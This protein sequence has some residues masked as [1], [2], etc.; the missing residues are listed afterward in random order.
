M[1]ENIKKLFKVKSMDIIAN[2]SLNLYSFAISTNHLR[3][4]TE[5]CLFLYDALNIKKH[6][7]SNVGDHIDNSCIQKVRIQLRKF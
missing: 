1:C 6:I 7:S 5:H 4:K 3:F 2:I